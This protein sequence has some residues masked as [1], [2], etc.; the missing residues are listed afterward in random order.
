MNLNDCEDS[1]SFQVD[2]VEFVLAQTRPNEFLNKK[3]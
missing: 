1:D 3:N 2:G